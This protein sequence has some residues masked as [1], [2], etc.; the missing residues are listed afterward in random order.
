MYR[1]F[2]LS[3]NNL[4]SYSSPALNRRKGDDDDTFAALALQLQAF[5]THL[6]DQLSALATCLKAL[7]VLK[8]RSFCNGHDTC[9]F[10]SNEIENDY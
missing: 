7:A 2:L 9:C 6:G 3:W 8:R 4:E 1:Q 5:S 10:V